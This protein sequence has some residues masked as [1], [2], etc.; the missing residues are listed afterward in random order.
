MLERDYQAYLIKK[1]KRMFPGC[2]VLKNDSGYIQGIPDLTILWGNMWAILEVKI[3]YGADEQ[4]N[5]GWYIE[6]FDDMSFAAFIYPENEDEVLD[7]LQQAFRH[8]RPA[9]F[10]KR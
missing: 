9:R 7:G 3:E 1:L 6:T 4:P 10:P 2:Q 5:Q 8:D